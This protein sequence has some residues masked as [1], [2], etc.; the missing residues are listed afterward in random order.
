LAWLKVATKLFPTPESNEVV[1]SL[2][3]QLQVSVEVEPLGV[4]WALTPKT[5]PV[6]K[7]VVDM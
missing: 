5:Q 6:V 7:V 1:T 4:F 3:E 2:S